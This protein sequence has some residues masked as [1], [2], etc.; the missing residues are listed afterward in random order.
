MKL[1]KGDRCP[2]FC[3]QNQFGETISIENLIGLKN[4]VIYFYPKDQTSVCTSQAC[5]FRD[6]YTVFSDLGCE[7]IGIS[8]DSVESHRVFADQNHLQ[9]QLL[10]DVTDQVRTLF[11]VPFSFFGLMKG[12]VTYIVDK[13]G[14]I[15]YVFRSQINGKRH[16]KNA[17]KF[18]NKM[19]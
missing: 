14:I 12:R 7:I 16:I 13:K 15:Q 2:S 1:K 18:L 3:L 10:A 6:S 9:F 4:L 5:S 11:G 19:K 8:S 17:V